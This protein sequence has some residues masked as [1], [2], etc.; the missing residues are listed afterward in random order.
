VKTRFKFLI[1]AAILLLVIGTV[2]FLHASVSNFSLPSKTGT[3]LAKGA[4]FTMPLT[5]SVLTNVM[6]WQINVTYTSSAVNMTSFTLGSAFTGSNTVTTSKS[7]PGIV[8]ISFTFEN[9]ATITATSTTTVVTYTFR[10]LVQSAGSSFHIVLS[11]ENPKFG[12]I[13]LGPDPSTV[14][15]YTTTDGVLSCFLSPTP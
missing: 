1:A 11:S 3:C 13:L 4:S 10:T 7:S 9:S 12:T 15:S 6:A 14:Q 5:A 8:S 2:P